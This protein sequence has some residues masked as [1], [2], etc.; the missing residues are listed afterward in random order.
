M[1]ATHYLDIMTREATISRELHARLLTAMHYQIK[2]GHTMAAAWPDWK[3]TLGEFGLVFRAF[4]NEVSLQGLT[5]SIEPLLK[6]NLVRLFPVALVP[7]TSKT[8]LFVRDRKNDKHSPSNIAR[9]LRR[10]AQRG[11]AIPEQTTSRPARMPH[12]L[13]MLS[14]TTSETFPLFVTRTSVAVDRLGGHEY[15]LGYALPDF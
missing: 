10:A 14:L 7:E 9:R 15:G 5:A 3:N 13:K 4:G 6:A 2:A 12:F 1:D 8:M 11:E